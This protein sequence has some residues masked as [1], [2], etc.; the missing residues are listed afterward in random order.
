MGSMSDDSLIT[1][2]LVRVN[3]SDDESDPSLTRIRYFVG[4]ILIM[5]MSV[6]K[7]VVPIHPD[8]EH[9]PGMV[10]TQLLV[11]PH[12]HLM[13]LGDYL[14]IVQGIDPAHVPVPTERWQALLE[15]T[16]LLLNPPMPTPDSSQD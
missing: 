12:E 4:D 5:D 14:S 13:L 10:L 1:V 2:P 15:R 3:L 7:A 16:K 9:F 8:G 11:T 6:E